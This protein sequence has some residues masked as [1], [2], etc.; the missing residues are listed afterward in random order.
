MKKEKY[1]LVGF[2]AINLNL[3]QNGPNLEKEIESQ[4]SQ[5]FEFI[6]NQI[7]C[8]VAKRLKE[9]LNEEVFLQ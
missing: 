6:W 8:G 4:A 5:L 3:V 7:P 1:R 2:R 9:K